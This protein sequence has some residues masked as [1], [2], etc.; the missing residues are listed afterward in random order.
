MGG[1]I[2]LLIGAL[3]ATFGFAVMRN[4][5]RLSFLSPWSR[6]AKGYYQRMVLDTPTRNQLRVLGVLVCLF[7]SSILTTS[8][9]GVFRVRV[10]DAVSEGLWMLMGCIFWLAWLSGLGILVW[11]L[12]KRRLPSYFAVWR[13][14][15]ELGPVEM[16]P[17]VTPRMAREALIFTVVLF[18]L[19]VI[20]STVAIF[21]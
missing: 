17:P 3:L 15:V 18:A 5:M 4:P 7:G 2:G 10:L 11:Q 8:L 20:A 12:F 16:F 6:G 21:R 9:A 1:L 19:A 13:A 14:G